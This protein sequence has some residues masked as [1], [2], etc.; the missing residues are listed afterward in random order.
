MDLI[1]FLGHCQK[2]AQMTEFTFMLAMFKVPIY[3][4]RHQE[5]ELSD[6]FV[7]LINY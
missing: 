5:L 7:F 6:C 1:Q 3:P 2:V 4:Y